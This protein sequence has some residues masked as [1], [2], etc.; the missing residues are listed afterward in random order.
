MSSHVFLSFNIIDV[1]ENCKKHAIFH[2]Y[3]GYYSTVSKYLSARCACIYEPKKAKQYFV[4]FFTLLSY[5]GRT[6]NLSS[7]NKCIMISSN[8]TSIVLHPRYPAGRKILRNVG[9][10]Y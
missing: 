8:I 9:T 10:T 5:A 6:T 4:N 1:E 7:D 2:V 3:K